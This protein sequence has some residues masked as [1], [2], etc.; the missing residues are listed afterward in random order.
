MNGSAARAHVE[1]SVIA[2]P[3]LLKSKLKTRKAKH[4]KRGSQNSSDSLERLVSGKFDQ[5]Y[6]VRNNPGACQRDRM[7][8]CKICGW[9]VRMAIH[10]EAN[11]GTIDGWAHPFA[12][13]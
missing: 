4:A 6:H 5:R 2:R 11:F 9:N 10:D 3:M 7:R 8:P 1:S 13:N 12:A